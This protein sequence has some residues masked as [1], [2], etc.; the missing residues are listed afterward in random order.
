MDGKQKTVRRWL[1][2]MWGGGKLELVDELASPDYVYHAPGAGAGEV[3]G[4][5]AL[6]QLVTYF[7]TVFPDLSNTIEDQFVSGDRVAT[8]GITRGTQ[9]GAMGNVAPTG[10]KVAI[11]WIMISRFE[12]KTIREDYEVWDGLV[13]LQD[14]GAYPRP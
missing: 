9:K 1:L 11:N 3:K 6:K 12:G 7:R 14:L 10:R 8:R 2:E 13:L 5:K 4:R